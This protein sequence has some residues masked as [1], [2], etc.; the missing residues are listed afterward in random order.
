MR[1]FLTRRPDTLWKDVTQRLDTGPPLWCTIRPP[2]G[3]VLIDGE[4]VTE[5]FEGRYF[6]DMVIDVWLPP[7]AEDG[8][9]HWVV[10]GHRVD[11][12]DPH[13]QLRLESDVTIEVH[14]G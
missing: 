3:G 8:F 5:T 4:L 11:G 6:R 12:N 13:L 9:S 14:H 7:S 1:E 10:N 2:A